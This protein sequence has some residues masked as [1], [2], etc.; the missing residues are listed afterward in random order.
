MLIDRDDVSGTRDLQHVDDGRTGGA[1]AVLDDLDILNALADDLQGV[2]H[3]RQHDDGCAVLVVVEHRD[4][5]V[6]FKPCLDLKST[7]GCGYPQ[8]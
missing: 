5:K 6:A 3:T 8:G 4:I 2:E 1:G 7:P